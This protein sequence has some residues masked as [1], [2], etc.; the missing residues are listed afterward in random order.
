MH[1]AT[2]YLKDKIMLDL[3]V[4]LSSGKLVSVLEKLVKDFDQFLVEVFVFLVIKKKDDMSCHKRYENF[5]IVF[6]KRQ[7]EITLL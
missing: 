6:Q 4:T 2:S 7:L 1:L 3:T 5:D